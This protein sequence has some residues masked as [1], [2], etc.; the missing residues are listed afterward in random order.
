MCYSKL[1]QPFQ[2][3]SDRYSCFSVSSPPLYRHNHDHSEISSGPDVATSGHTMFFLKCLSSSS[4]RHATEGSQIGRNGVSQCRGYPLGNSRRHWTVVQFVR[5]VVYAHQTVEGER[6]R[7]K[8]NL[9]IQHK[10]LQS[11]H[12]SVCCSY[13]CD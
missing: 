12:G 8:P 5:I 11:D 9:H 1:F 10:I 7:K 2:C 13:E 4:Q 6:V 3:H